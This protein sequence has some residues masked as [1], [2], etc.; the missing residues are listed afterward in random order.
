MFME[1]YIFKQFPA[2]ILGY[3]KT[4]KI[5]TVRLTPEIESTFRGAVVFPA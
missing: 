2:I 5:L 4:G 1:L 3:P